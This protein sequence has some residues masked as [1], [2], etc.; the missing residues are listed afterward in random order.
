MWAED[1]QACWLRSSLEAQHTSPWQHRTGDQT[2]ISLGSGEVTSPGAGGPQEVRAGSLWAPAPSWGWRCKHL[3]H[4]F[5]LLM[6]GAA[7]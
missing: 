5:H 4:D 2:G 1:G 3:P 6:N 7:C